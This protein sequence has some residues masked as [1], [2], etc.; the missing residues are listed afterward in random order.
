MKQLYDS[1]SVFFENTY[2]QMVLILN[3]AF[4]LVLSYSSAI[5]DASIARATLVFTLI[6]VIFL[7]RFN[8]YKM[9]LARREVE[10]L[11][12]VWGTNKNNKQ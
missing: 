4:Q 3:A 5:E 7:A 8:F 10:N 11:D 1:L 9:K 2:A 12:K 6:S